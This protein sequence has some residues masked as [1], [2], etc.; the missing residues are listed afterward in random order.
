MR[1]RGAEGGGGRKCQKKPKPKQQ[2][3]R[4][5]EALGEQEVRE[6][7][8]RGLKRHAEA[9]PGGASSGM[10]MRHIRAIRAPRR[11]VRREVGIGMM[12]PADHDE[13]AGEVARQNFVLDLR[14]LCGT[15]TG[16]AEAHVPVRGSALS[17]YT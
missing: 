10:R 8:R 15:G 9:P 4:E 7:T 17:S 11:H 5:P 6:G 16:H 2:R 13:V 12:L 3:R 14:V 1:G